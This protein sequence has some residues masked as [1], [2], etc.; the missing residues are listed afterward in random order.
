MRSAD[1]GFKQT[2]V[3]PQGTSK[4]EPVIHR[5]LTHTLNPSTRETEAGGSVSS[6]PDWSTEFQDS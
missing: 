2:K 4:R 1:P 5:V 3:S 6:R